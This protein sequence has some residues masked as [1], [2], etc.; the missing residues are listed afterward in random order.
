MSHC[1]LE[2]IVLRYKITERRHREV[3]DVNAEA[4]RALLQASE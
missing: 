4:T 1:T 2:I 3:L